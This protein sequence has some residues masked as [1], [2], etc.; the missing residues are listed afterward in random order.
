M[1]LIKMNFCEHIP[2][3]VYIRSYSVYYG[4]IYT[5]IIKV[6]SRLAFGQTSFSEEIHH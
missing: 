1:Y 3:S 2:I 6:T 4:Y 5:S